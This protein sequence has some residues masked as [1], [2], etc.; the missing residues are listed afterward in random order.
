MP[1]VMIGGFPL[2]R[3][4]AHGA[5]GELHLASDPAT[6]APIAIKTVRLHGGELTRER[7]LRESNA[8]AR[9]HH[10]SIVRC[11]ATGI[12]GQGESAIGWIAMEWVAGSD[13]ARY[14]SPARLLP[15]PL[16]LE[17]LAQAAEA[18]GH[19]HALGV[20]HRDIKPANLLFNPGRGRLKI[21]DFGCAHLSDAERSRSGVLAGT[22]VYMAPE[23]LAGA[24]VDGRCDLYAL[25]VVLFELLTGHLPFESASMGELLAD[26]T[27]RPA[28]PL[29]AL[30]PDL[31]GELA[32]LIERLLAKQPEARLADG[33][34]VA[35]ELRHIAQALDAALV[36]PGA[37]A[38]AQAGTMAVHPSPTPP[39]L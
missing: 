30:R 32:A 22:P 35:H 23:Q 5:L 12:E 24:P 25:G 9:L 8:A 15:E 19:A 39:S 29:A 27:R 21:A 38:P 31:P 33:Q 36:S 16:V 3:T 17:L 28:P 37:P 26:I 13:L 10:P 7:F 20:V 4:F 11:H 6:G 18:L 2:V 14:T 1:G 34:A